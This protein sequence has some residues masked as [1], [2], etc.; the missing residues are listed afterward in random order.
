MGSLFQFHFKNL[1]SVGN[2]ELRYS[3]NWRRNK[4]NIIKSSRSRALIL[5]SWRDTGLMKLKIILYKIMLL[6]LK[7]WIIMIRLPVIQFAAE[8]RRL[9]RRKSKSNW[10]LL[11]SRLRTKSLRYQKWSQGLLMSLELISKSADK[12]QN[13]L[14]KEVAKWKA[15]LLLIF[16]KN[17]LKN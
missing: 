8:I 17:A 9:S 14:F 10:R 5:N 16:R 15:R 13:R 11:T 3:C 1:R 4:Q 12:K 6:L 7:Y 2:A